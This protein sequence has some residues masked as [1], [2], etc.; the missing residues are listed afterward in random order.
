MGDLNRHDTVG[1][2]KRLKVRSPYPIQFSRDDEERKFGLTISKPPELLYMSTKN[3][4][5]DQ[6]DSA[7]V[8]D[9]KAEG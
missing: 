2:F 6:P 9:L 1:V 3:K 4:V 5:M 7:L 8:K